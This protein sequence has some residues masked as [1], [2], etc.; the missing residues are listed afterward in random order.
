MQ[1]LENKQ[2]KENRLALPD[3]FPVD[4]LNIDDEEDRAIEELE[5]FRQ[6][7]F[8]QAFGDVVEDVETIE[9]ADGNVE[10]VIRRRHKTYGDQKALEK[11][12]QIFGRP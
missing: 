10:R 12:L 3:D 6:R 9:D 7:L 8:V 1:K 2:E 5:A 11:Y 4:V